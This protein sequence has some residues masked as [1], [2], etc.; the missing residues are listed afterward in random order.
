MRWVGCTTCRVARTGSQKPHQKSCQGP[1]SLSPHQCESFW[2]NLSWSSEGFF[3]FLP[4]INVGVNLK[5]SQRCPTARGLTAHISGC[6]H[7]LGSGFPVM[8]LSSSCRCGQLPW[9]YQPGLSSDGSPS[10][11]STSFTWGKN[12]KWDCMISTVWQLTAT[13][14][15]SSSTN[16]TT[17]FSREN[18][19]AACE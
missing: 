11:S 17:V 8:V 1:H 12:R 18:R 14:P 10:L 6:W 2:A 3:Q 16:L 15:Q 13:W 9:E 5:V 7:T 19:I 4:K